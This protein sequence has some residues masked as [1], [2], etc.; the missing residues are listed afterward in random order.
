ME[1]KE[2]LTSEILE[3]TWKPLA[4]HFARGAV[5]FL[6]SE[7]DIIDVGQAMATDDVSVIKRWLDDGLIYPPTSEQ[8]TQFH[9]DSDQIFN[10]LI[11]EPYVLIQKKGLS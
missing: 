7:L 8:A 11:I 10:M 5:Y 3:T 1:L 9:E 2:K 6:E 4:E